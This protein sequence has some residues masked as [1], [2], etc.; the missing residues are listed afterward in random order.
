M[1]RTRSLRPRR[2]RVVTEADARRVIESWLGLHERR[3]VPLDK[4]LR[5]L[6]AASAH[7]LSTGSASDDRVRG[8]FID[9]DS[10]EE[11]VVLRRVD[12]EALHD[13]VDLLSDRDER[14]ELE[15]AQRDAAQGELAS[16]EEVRTEL[17]AR[18]G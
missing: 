3:H 6:A 18:S 2:P 8:R 7:L 16:L 4:S 9:P 12:Y 1:S 5:R 13:T 14:A 17:D 11:F 15:Q 10:G